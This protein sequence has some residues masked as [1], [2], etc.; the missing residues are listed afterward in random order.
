MTLSRRSFF[1]ASGVGLL[2]SHAFAGLR[3]LKIGVTEWN[4]KLTAKLEAVDLANR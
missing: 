2:S 4:L 1:A 3:G